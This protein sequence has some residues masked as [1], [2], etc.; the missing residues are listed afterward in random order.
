MSVKIRNQQESQMTRTRAERLLIDLEKLKSDISNIENRFGVL[1]I[2]YTAICEDAISRLNSIKDQLDNS[3][4]TGKKDHDDLKKRI[5]NL[6]ARFR[7]GLIT[8]ETYLTQ[9]ETLISHHYPPST[10]VQL[11]IDK[12]ADGIE[13]SLDKMGDGLIFPLVLAANLYNGLKN[14]L[15]K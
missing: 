7:L 1:S 2:D 11:V 8:Q 4:D 13:V 3:H 6:E 10:G 14:Q 9:K 5:Q 15:L 12:V